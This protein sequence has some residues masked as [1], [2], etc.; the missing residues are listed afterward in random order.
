MTRTRCKWG[1]LVLA[2][3][4][5]W[6]PQYLRA[7]WVEDK[8]GK[9]IIHV[10]LWQMPDPTRTD[11]NSQAQWAVVKRF[12]ER[13]P[14]I[15][16]E[17]LAARYKA[18]PAKYGNHNWDNV[19]INLQ[20]FS[21]I[22]IENQ[23]MDS[24]PLMAIAGG[25]AP[26]VLYVNFRA[27]D[28][29]I[30]QGFLYPLDKPEDG[31]LTGMTKE[32]QDFQI[33]PKTWPVIRR[34]GPSGE[35]H[36]WA[37]PTGGVL[38]KVMLYRK[39]LLEEAGVP[40]PHNNWTWEDLYQACKK[41]ADP[42]QGRY[43]IAFGRGP[44]ESWYWV[45]FLWSAGGEVME[46]DEAT[47]EWRACFDTP[48]AA[49]AVEFYTRLCSEVWYD[50]EN[51]RRY[52]YAAKEADTYRKWDQGQIGFMSTYIDE[53]LFSTI[54]P[55][56]VG[57]VPVPI[58][59]GGNRG[60][61]LN[62]RMQGIFSGVKD[63]VVRDAAWEYLKFIDSKEA[64]EV[65]TRMMV[66]GGLGRFVNPRYLRMFGYEDIIRLAPKGW[67]EIFEVAIATGKPEPYGRNCQLV[68]EYMTGPLVA[69]ELLGLKDLLPKVPES[70]AKAIH[71]Q[72]VQA[73]GEAPGDSLAEIGEMLQR[74]TEDQ[75][76]ERMTRAEAQ[77]RKAAE[78]DPANEALGAVSKA[79]TAAMEKMQEQ[80]LGVM[81]ASLKSAAQ[82]A[83]EKMIG[84]LTPR[85]KTI[86]RSAAAVVLT[87]IAA[88]FFFVMRKIIKTFTPP[89]VALSQKKETWGF[90]RYAMAYLILV[91]AVL[92]IFL[93]QY[94][95]L[96]I[97]SLMAFQ[98][99]QI[100]GDSKVVYIDNFA[101]L[102]WDGAWWTSVWNSVRYSLLIIA[103]TFLP[104]VILAVLLDE[105]PIGK[106]FYRTLFYLPAV[107]TGLV[108]IYL[109]RSFYE[110]TEFGVLNALVM[111][112]P[113]IGY[114]AL[115]ILLFGIMHAFAERLHVHQ[116]Y[117]QSD[118][119][120]VLGL[121]LF[122][123]AYRFA[124]KILLFSEED[125]LPLLIMTVTGMLFWLWYKLIRSYS[126]RYW[127]AMGVISA[128]VL[129]L[130][131]TNVDIKAMW[132]ADWSAGV[133]DCI[134][135][136]L[137][138]GPLSRSTALLIGVGTALG[139][140]W[141]G[142]GRRREEWPAWLVQAGYWALAV[143]IILF[144]A[145]GSALGELL[146]ENLWLTQPEPFRWLQDSDT[147]MLCCVIPMI[148]AGMGPGCLIYLAALKGIAPDFYEAADIDGA[149]FVD[150]ILFVVV[151]ILKPLLII[152]FVG[153]FIGAWNSSAFILAMTGGASNTEVAG[154]HIFYKAY[155]H[156]KFGPAAAM[157]WVLGFM[158]IGFTLHQ[159]RILS[160]L[161]F[162][163]TGN[164]D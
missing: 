19:E 16:A 115:A 162:K 27:S 95:P 111:S 65:Q 66:E 20:R 117:W 28:T 31:Y 160:R 146:R 119:C 123:F 39:D 30:Q 78:A 88:A 118:L 23:G 86:R 1:C 148:W 80:R 25:V 154:L 84:V 151:P 97:G 102:M 52:G 135:L 33:H 87:M 79:L 125:R 53:K 127:V 4:A 130:L 72:F 45:T 122:V 128:G 6:W 13:F 164:K 144:A 96:I 141:Y 43:G 129:G 133:A 10:K 73:C 113:V 93:W 142:F 56:L 85:Q 3:V 120:N 37:K 68:Y 77:L 161:E 107:I 131:V 5:V 136:G 60:G 137:T 159:L 138:D 152:N 139:G 105:I 51:K 47:D 157:A 145:K 36:V 34:K 38:G 82:V 49:A 116:S 15:F 104:P 110:P 61:E 91:P 35:T 46:Y 163:T 58:G 132:N 149:T 147:A 140:L 11:T 106:V 109:W 59:P 124:D 18:D 32:E 89:S 90:R 112:V 74:S 57:M 134:K 63:P 98:D 41:I 158:L 17:K 54:N 92:S 55:D 42:G 94:V 14:A 8:D 24:R 153:V 81:M 156:L 100:V 76:V 29:Y 48:E 70:T 114:V 12:Y 44:H 101:N 150:K 9:T 22:T 71:A 7:G 155:M 69:M 83:N 108:V 75:N 62:S 99:Y 67:E 26:D 126:W 50:K 103:L 121:A 21:G 40:A 143:V 2:L 64:M